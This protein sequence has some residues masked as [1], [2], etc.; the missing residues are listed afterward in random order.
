MVARSY[1]LGITGSTL[2]LVCV[3]VLAAK[4][5]YIH[6]LAEIPIFLLW[7]ATSGLREHPSPS[8]Q[9]K[10]APLQLILFQYSSEV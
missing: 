5:K 2:E 4:I 1:S 8:L 3:W 9:P 10:V 7:M 6:K